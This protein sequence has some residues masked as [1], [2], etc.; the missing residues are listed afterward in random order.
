[1]ARNF[2][3]EWFTLN[4]EEQQTRNRM[5]EH[6]RSVR[7]EDFQRVSIAVGD[8]TNSTV[9]RIEKRMEILYQLGEESRRQAVVNRALISLCLL[10]LVVLAFR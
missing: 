8:V 9:H 1:M 10:A 4:L 6:P 5:D 3:K 7:E 2:E